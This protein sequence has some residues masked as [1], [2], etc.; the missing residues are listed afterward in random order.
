MSKPLRVAVFT[1][2]FPS[3]S[4][5][6]IARQIAGLLDLGHKVSVYADLRPDATSPVQ[7][8]AAHDG[9]RVRAIYFRIPEASGY[10]ERSAF[11]PWGRTWLPG[12]T[13][14]LANA[15]RLLHAL[16]VVM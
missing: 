4:E 9:L 2:T 16:P 8:G 14:P 1:G 10:W 3:V 15:K 11:P 12:R 7:S 5:T 6:F 13:L